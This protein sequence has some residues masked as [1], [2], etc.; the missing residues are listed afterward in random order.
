[1]GFLS[2]RPPNFPEADHGRLALFTFFGTAAVSLLWHVL[3]SA[4]SAGELTNGY[5]HGG[6]LID[7]IGES[8]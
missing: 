4:P 7:F 8:E 5:L 6:L 2:P 1:M 3:A